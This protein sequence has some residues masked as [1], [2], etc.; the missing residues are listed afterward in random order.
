MKR[1]IVVWI[2]CCGLTAGSFAILVLEDRSLG[3]P[4][5]YS[6]PMAFASMLAMASALLAVAQKLWARRPVRIIQVVPPPAVAPERRRPGRAAE[7]VVL[8]DVSGTVAFSRQ[9]A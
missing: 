4:L 6:V 1:I 9:A 5:P 7:G 2:V 3:V 8:L